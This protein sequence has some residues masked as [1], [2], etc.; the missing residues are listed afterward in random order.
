MTDEPELL[1]IEEAADFFAPGRDVALLAPPRHR[2]SSGEHDS[3]AAAV[4]APL[5]QDG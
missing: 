1:T 2:V 3:R 5:I 4:R